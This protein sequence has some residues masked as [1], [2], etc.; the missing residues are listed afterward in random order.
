MVEAAMAREDDLH[1]HHVSQRLML[2]QVHALYALMGN[3]SV[4]QLQLLNTSTAITRTEAKKN[5]NSLLA[6][7]S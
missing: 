2:H 1:L 3:C 6:C 7:P 5:I 4:I